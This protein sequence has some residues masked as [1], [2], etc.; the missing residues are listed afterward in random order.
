MP[1]L[2]QHSLPYLLCILLAMPALAEN[3]AADTPDKETPI[4]CTSAECGE[5]PENEFVADADDDPFDGEIDPFAYGKDWDYDNSGVLDGIYQC[6]MTL[7]ADGQIRSQIY[8]SVNGKSN[9]DAVFIIGEIE[10]RPDAYFGW[11][12]G[13]V[14]DET[15]GT[16]FRF[17]G[18]TS[19][20]EDFA[21]LATYQP[22]GSVRAQGQAV[23]LF[24]P[25]GQPVSDVLA[26]IA[27]QSIW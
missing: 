27:C 4:V 5:T 23:I 11:G 20:N 19:E 25:P 10:A 6:E 14:E 26:K 21:L 7:S 22:D 17:S 2:F 15:D 18:K 24:K 1:A 13:R 3:A 8:V 9:G 16:T 12:I